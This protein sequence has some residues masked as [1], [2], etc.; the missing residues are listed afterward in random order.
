MSART[1]VLL[2]LAGCADQAAPPPSSLA[3]PTDAP[4]AHDDDD[5]RVSQVGGFSTPE[6]VL[7]D[8]EADVY[9]VTNI[10]GNALD[11]D[12]NG[13]ISRVSPPP[14][15]RIVDLAWI[16]GAD[17]GVTLHGPKGMAL[18]GDTLYVADVGGVRRFDRH[19]GEPRGLVELPG[20][21]FVND[22]VALDGV[23]YATDT[24][25]DRALVA[26]PH[27][28]IWRID[29]DRATKL[30]TGTDL[31][32]PNGLAVIDGAVWTVGFA[33]GA[34]YPIAGGAREVLPAGT[35]DGLVVLPDGRRVVTSWEAGGLFVGASG[36]WTRLPW[37]IPSPADVGVDPKRGLLLV[38]SF[39]ENRIELHAFGVGSSG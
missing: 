2:A 25:L 3:P 22:V 18:A 17:P 7:W 29:G 23:I 11:A 15:P 34:L 19:T 4:L 9:L 27:Q 1:I 14:A 16:D 38:P 24:G 33:S 10:V 20:T 35:L 37:S 31:G 39:A 21:T 26:Q 30:A 8:D 5:P 13:F 32:G 36:G 12:D 6:S 28:A